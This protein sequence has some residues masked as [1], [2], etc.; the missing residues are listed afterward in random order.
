[1]NLVIVGSPGLKLDA[2]LSELCHVGHGQVS[3]FNP[4][5][6]VDEQARLNRIGL[7]AGKTP[8]NGR[9]AVFTGIETEAEL[10]LLRERGAIIAHIYGELGSAYNHI[11]IAVGDR[12]VLSSHGNYR[13]P[14]HLY[15]PEQLL[16]ECHIEHARKK[17]G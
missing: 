15:T 10:L 12:M 2:V 1:M 13:R 4:A 7:E 8:F 6:L 9:V 17:A 14:Q 5:Y 16:S 3:L 11:K